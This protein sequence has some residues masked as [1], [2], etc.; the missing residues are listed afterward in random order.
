LNV[1]AWPSNIKGFM[2]PKSKAPEP[3]HNSEVQAADESK[4]IWEQENAL[5]GGGGGAVAKLFKA[6]QFDNPGVLDIDH[7]TNDAALFARETI[8]NSWDAAREWRRACDKRGKTVPPFEIDF[9]FVEILSEQ[10]LKFIDAMG[11]DEH[12][13]VLEMEQGREKAKRQDFDLA[14]KKLLTNIVTNKVPLRVLRVV[15]RAGM[16]MPGNFERNQSRMTRALLRV[17]RANDDVGAGGAFGFGKAGLIQASASRIIF[18]YS[19]FQE[20]ADDPGITRRFMGVTYWKDHKRGSL[21]LTGWARFGEPVKLKLTGEF[22]EISI[23]SARPYDNEVADGYAAQLGL[24]IRS[25]ADDRGTGT[26]FLLVDPTITAFELKK[27]IERYWWPAMLNPLETL[28]V[29]IR[30]YDGSDASPVVP[31]GDKHMAPFVRAY[32]IATSKTPPQVENEQRV[33]FGKIRGSDGNLYEL[34]SLAMIAD[35]SGWSFPDK[36]ADTENV[37]HRSMIALVRGPRMVVNYRTFARLGTP[38]VRGVFVADQEVD[39]LLRLTENPTHTKWDPDVKLPES[40]AA[41][42][43]KAVGEEVRAALTEFQRRFAPPAPK[44]DSRSLPV[45]EELSQLMRGKRL[46]P[47]APEQRQVL[48][49]LTE[50]AHTET[51]GDVLRCKARVRFRVADWVWDEISE[52]EVKVHVSLSIA[53]VEDGGRGGDLK[54][55]AKPSNST[56]TAA[57]AK[58]GKVVFHGPL[59]KGDEVEF[60]VASEAYSPDWTVRFTPAAEITEPQVKPTRPKKSKGNA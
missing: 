37:E 6:E 54:I 15:E 29:R 33:D 32:Q 57:G 17:G 55:T 50:A 38:H 60:S 51:H 36:A 16:G 41:S 28:R 43:A 14:D 9:E 13:R 58:S 1:R 47:P 53:Y 12:S 10:R 5:F 23:S 22:G 46:V 26:T 31:H 7:P 48:I 18:A 30:D 40:P 11:L 39:D 34:G 52:T 42:L 24:D 25:Q 8:Q 3:P 49:S 2:P 20:V 21:S 59:G 35:P 56:F 19:A 4:W 44:P 27:A 45:L